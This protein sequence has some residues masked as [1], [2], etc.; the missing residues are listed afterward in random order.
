MIHTRRVVPVGKNGTEQND[1]EHRLQFS[2]PGTLSTCGTMAPQRG[3]EGQSFVISAAV[4]AE[5]ARGRR[6]SALHGNERFHRN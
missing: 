2:A 6:S 5:P 1:A 4:P 3:T